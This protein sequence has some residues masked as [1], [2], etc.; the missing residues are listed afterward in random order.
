[1]LINIT[2]TAQTSA[3]CPNVD[4]STVW[5]KNHFFEVCR[6]ATTNFGC[7]QKLDCRAVPRC[8]S[9]RLSANAACTPAANRIAR[10]HATAQ[11]HAAAHRQTPRW[12]T[13]FAHLSAA[14]WRRQ[15]H[16]ADWIARFVA[17]VFDH[18]LV[19]ASSTTRMCTTC[20]HLT[21]AYGKG[22]MMKIQYN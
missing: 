3:A 12:W 1:M 15:V 5:M 9:N 19:P 13:M 18:W 17:S 6:T 16:V 21:I 8:V 22:S 11:P 4:Y 7:C 14:D 2:I 10:S 20:S